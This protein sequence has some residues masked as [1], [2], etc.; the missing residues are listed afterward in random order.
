[1]KIKC[2]S[3]DVSG[4]PASYLKYHQNDDRS[5]PLLT[6]GK[7]YIVTGVEYREGLLLYIAQLDNAMVYRTCPLLFSVVEET[8]PQ[9]WKVS[10]NE[11]EG[12]LVMELSFAEWFTQGF[13]EAYY[14]R[15]VTALTIVDNKLKSYAH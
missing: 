13:Q 1:M 9:D 11:E 3:I 10:V 6:K 8:V 2:L 15:D 4:I 14:D 12:Q 7:D 5:D